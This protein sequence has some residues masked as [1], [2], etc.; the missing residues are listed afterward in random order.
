MKSKIALVISVCL[1]GLVGCGKKGLLG[2]GDSA[3]ARAEEL[4]GDALI[5]QMG[6]QSTFTTLKD[7]YIESDTNVITDIEEDNSLVSNC[8][9]T[10]NE[11]EKQPA[12]HWIPAGTSFT[13]V[14]SRI[15]EDRSFALAIEDG[16][17]F[18]V[19]RLSCWTLPGDT[20]PLTISFLR[21]ALAPTFAV[22]AR[23]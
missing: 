17:T 5:D 7:L 15:G 10:L 14:S 3:P 13:V 2:R 21:A 9:L 16:D 19:P 4:A 22:D 20:Q 8:S 12:A 18:S 6:S 11:K 23:Q 1:V